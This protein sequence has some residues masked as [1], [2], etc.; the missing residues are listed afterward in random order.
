MSIQRRSWSRSWVNSAIEY[1]EYSNSG[2]QNKASNGQTSMQMP[3]YMHSAKSIANRSSV[4][5]VRMRPPPPG[6]GTVSLRESM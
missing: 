2:D 1:V 6:A 3:Q 5:R 4:L